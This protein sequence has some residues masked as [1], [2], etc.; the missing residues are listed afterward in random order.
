MF[1]CS[2]GGLVLDYTVVSYDE[3]AVFQ[4]VING[5]CYICHS[6]M[7]TFDKTVVL[8]SVQRVMICGQMHEQ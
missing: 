4:P 8:S 2:L 3:V 6:H 5:T 7:V 1:F